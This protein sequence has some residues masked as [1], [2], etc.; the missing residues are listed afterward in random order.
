MNSRRITSIIIKNLI[1]MMMKMKIKM[2][3][4]AVNKVKVKNNKTNKYLLLLNSPIFP[5]YQIICWFSQE[6]K[7][8][9]KYLNN[10]CS[11]S[12]SNYH[13]L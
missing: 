12:S 6:K 1:R 4:R 3:N 5:L 11:N 8:N 13:H 9:L 2:I 10:N 7:L